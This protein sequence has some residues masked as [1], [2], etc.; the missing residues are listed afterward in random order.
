MDIDSRPV[1]GG[2]GAKPFDGAVAPDE[3]FRSRP[4]SELVAHSNWKARKEGFEKVQRA[5][6]EN[7]QL[8]LDT[9]K[10]IVAEGN[11]VV[12]EAAIEALAAV[13]YH[14]S[15][16]ERSQLAERAL[17]FVIEKGITGRP[18]A[19]QAGQ[20]FVST[21]VHEGCARSVFSALLPAFAHRAPKNRLAAAQLAASLVADYGVQHFPVKEIL[22]AMQPLFNDANAQVRK[23]A[24]SLCC[25]CYRYIGASIKGFLTDLRDVQLQ[26]LQKQFESVKVGEAPPKN[27][28]GARC[29]DRNG[30]PSTEKNATVKPI[31]SLTGDEEGCVADDVGFQLLDESPVIPKL[32]KKFFRITLDKETTWQKRVEYVNE[33]LLPLLAAP[34]FRAKDD[35]HELASMMKVYLVDPQAPLM[36]LGFKMI[37]ECARGLRSD[38]GPYAR[39]YVAPLL[40]KLKDKK[41]SVQLHVMK[42]L[43]DLIHF[44]CVSMDQCNEEI[45]QALQ[46]KNPTQRAAIVNFC[47]HMIDVLGDKNR[48]TKLGKSTA[49]LTRLVNDEKSSIRD[50]AYVL[51]D[52]LIRAN[53]EEQYKSVLSTLD[54]N[55]RHN[56]AAAVARGASGVGPRSTGSRPASNLPTPPAS[57]VC[58]A[59]PSSSPAK[60]MPRLDDVAAETSSVGTTSR[61][62][63][64]SSGA[65]SSA[66]RRLST[67]HDESGEHVPRTSSTIPESTPLGSSPADKLSF[68]ARAAASRRAGSER[69]PGGGA[70]TPSKNAPE[71]GI[72]LES[73]LPPKME[74]VTMI[75]GFLNGDNAV[76]DMVRSTEW[77]RRQ[78][79]VTKLL[80]MVQQWTP[81]QATRGMD[82]LVVYVRVHPSFR[83]P[84]F[85]VFLLI[86]QVFQEAVRK[87]TT[88][89]LGAGYAIVSGFTPRLSEAKN[90]PLVR[91]VCELVAEKL[92][93]R[94]VVRHMLETVTVVKTPKLIQEVCEYVR[95][96][97]QQQPDSEESD[98]DAVDVRGMLHFV[99]AVC[100]DVNHTGVRQ[101]MVLLLADLRRTSRG[102][103][104]IDRCVASLPPPLPAM[105]EREMSKPDSSR[106]NVP[107]AGAPLPPQRVNASGTGSAAAPTSAPAKRVRTSS[108]SP[109]PG[110]RG[111]ASVPSS[112]HPPTAHRR[113]V[114][115]DDG[116]A[117]LNRHS[118]ALLN[119]S[120]ANA[121]P[122]APASRLSTRR[123]SSA[124]PSPRASSAAGTV[125]PSSLRPILLEITSGDD[126]RDRL[127][128]LRHAEEFVEETPR[129]LPANCA[130]P[131]LKVLQ[132]RF[133]E[134]N[135]NIVVDVL[136]FIPVVVGASVAGE[137]AAAL[138]RLA[139]GVLAMLGDQKTA[140]REEARSVAFLVM[141]VVGLELMLPLLQKPLASESNVCRQNVLEMMVSGFE[142]LPPEATLPRAGTQ[143]LAPAVINSMMDRILEVRIIAEQVLGWMIGVVGE[144]FVLQCVQRL[145]PAE[146][147]VVMPAIER[148][149]EHQ[150]STAQ[151]SEKPEPER[152]ESPSPSA[153]L[154]TTLNSLC[155]NEEGSRTTPRMAATSRAG[156]AAVTVAAADTPHRRGSVN[157]LRESRSSARAA[158][159]A[160]EGDGVTQLS[161]TAL[162]RTV[163]TSAADSVVATTAAPPRERSPATC[164]KKEVA[165]G[166]SAP[167]TTGGAADPAKTP[168][169]VYV[170]PKKKAA[171]K[172]NNSTTAAQAQLPPTD[173]APSLPRDAVVA[174]ESKREKYTIRE[175]LVGL[176]SATPDVAQTMCGDF[177]RHLRAGVDCGTPEVIQAMVERLYENTQN[178]DVDLAKAL[179]DSL[180]ALFETSK[181]TARCHSQL[182]L[183]IT[184]VFFDCLLSEKF[185]L[186]EPVIKAL[187]ALT[188]KMIEGCGE[189]DMFTALMNRLSSYSG[190]YLASGHKSD[191]KYIQVTVKC[192]MRVDLT[193]VSADT[194]V[195]YCHEYLLQHP[196]SAFRN[197]DDVS[198]RTVKTILQN[199]TKRHG[200]SLLT[201]AEKLVGP[202]NLVT[203]FIRACLDMQEKAAKDKGQNE[204]QVIEESRHEQRAS[205]SPAPPTKEEGT[206]TS[207]SAVAASPGLSTTPQRRTTTPTP[208]KRRQSG[209]VDP[210][211]SVKAAPVSPTAPT[212]KPG[213][214]PITSPVSTSIATATGGSG[215]A[216]TL[217]PPAPVTSRRTPV[218]ARL[219]Q[220]A[221]TPIHSGRG[222]ATARSSPPPCVTPS[223]TTPTKVNSGHGDV[224][225]ELT[226][227]F[228]RIR[229]HVTSADG[230]SDLYGFLKTTP[231]SRYE[232]AFKLQF[233][234]CSEAF[235]MYIKRKL[236]RKL[237][238]DA[239]KPA[240]FQLPS[241]IQNLS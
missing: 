169:T 29:A 176:R 153:N 123:T 35:Y 128:G 213:A 132:S 187:N 180:T 143:L 102:T 117:P 101:E 113:T 24:V 13:L 77:P 78:E 105:Y 160:K 75:L 9:L 19:A 85:Q 108:Q 222:S 196:P 203:H 95:E 184:G 131:L 118:V 224:T 54:D 66:A 130:V 104:A 226:D 165:A 22:K 161:T 45:D 170:T 116:D 114:S 41:L 46:S 136:R 12:Q 59:T 197:L 206:A 119:A 177:N 172:G 218:K 166:K 86:A 241:V 3:D 23:E 73:S 107:A 199:A 229:N 216:R 193:K 124:G 240:D 17:P 69:R 239:A 174:A 2:V 228:A 168:D 81:A 158:T 97:V 146:Q 30:G 188:L 212:T 14:C 15:E 76:L 98:A 205:Q 91:E 4:V 221:T 21:L 94:F 149:L 237:E 135:K 142:Q 28:K 80:T 36:L 31:V 232:D 6:I 209:H 57:G 178:F 163:T 90:K 72:S 96:A 148:Q 37:Q 236:E 198:I 89:S 207:A 44:N 39:T 121:L 201:T 70:A 225:K 42:T 192:I 230:I 211:V 53:G 186:Q 83:E 204:Q 157:S 64:A 141:R 100:T 71:D 194:T 171:A 79:G 106:S 145:K 140:L 58:S 47:V 1:G 152:R 120:G 133:E 215:V 214:A 147:Q 202:Q 10:P 27:I 179:I 11:A 155:D 109:G 173:T 182:L 233:N 32:P 208:R 156:A 61:M 125:P 122:S 87:V 48:Y 190:A 40:D 56:M 88:L 231:P 63:T 159:H 220:G 25:Q 137:C 162:E 185:S 110:A 5:P 127:A 84:I 20:N 52:K 191:L 235:R 74:A 55:Q 67:S 151:A 200:P 18:K 139:P 8:V 181:C 183:R 150:R 195:V 134:A 154:N 7:K 129:P 62:R 115:S 234:R 34:R 60:K 103:P 51:L 38:F 210:H 227:V 138:R 43:E 68:S 82:Y 167:A 144:D 238:E 93:K 112:F 219:R 49:M 50:I 92:G 65:A 223:T 33:N 175:I 26:E 111:R 217:S 126:W 99:R 164:A 189:D 16:A